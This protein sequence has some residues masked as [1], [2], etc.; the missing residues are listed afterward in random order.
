MAYGLSDTVGQGTNASMGE[1]NLF[2]GYRELMLSEFRA[3]EQFGQGH[4]Q[5]YTRASE[6]VQLPIKQNN[7]RSIQFAKTCRVWH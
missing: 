3:K 1:E 5:F 2:A 6:F 7:C 4:D